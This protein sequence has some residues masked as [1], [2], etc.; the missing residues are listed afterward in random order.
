MAQT[1]AWLWEWGTKFLSFRLDFGDV[2]FTLF[3]FA[4]G[5]VIIFMVIA[6]VRRILE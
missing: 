1:F 3:D 5:A 2:S 6:L 4:L